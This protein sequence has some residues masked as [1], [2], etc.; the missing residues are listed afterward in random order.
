MDSHETC[1]LENGMWKFT[2]G[3]VKVGAQDG[4]NFKK[5]T[6][7][8]MLMGPLANLRDLSSIDIC[9]R[10]VFIGLV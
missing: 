6:D 8:C 10:Y 1:N 5:L 7:C 4:Q 2:M 3:C 9:V